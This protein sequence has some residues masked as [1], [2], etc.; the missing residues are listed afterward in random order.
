MLARPFQPFQNLP[1]PLTGQR[2]ECR[3]RRHID[4]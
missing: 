1:S 4:N 2:A 3:V